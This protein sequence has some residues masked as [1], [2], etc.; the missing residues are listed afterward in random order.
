MKATIRILPRAESELL[1]LPNR[2]IRKV[3]DLLDFLS[4]FPLGAQSAE[5]EEAPD[6]RRGVAGDYLI[7]YRYDKSR[8]TVLV[9]TI[10]HGA[11]KPLASEDLGP[12]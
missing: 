6:V 2:D 3:V 12:F 5:F 8:N 11:R 1:E 10:R 4:I 7:Y 9:Y